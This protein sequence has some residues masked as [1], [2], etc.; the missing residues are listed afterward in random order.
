MSHVY[1]MLYT[2]PDILKSETVCFRDLRWEWP[3]VFGQLTCPCW[4]PLRCRHAAFELSRP[5]LF[6]DTF[7]LKPLFS[8]GFLCCRPHCYHSSR[9]L[10]T[11]FTWSTWHSVPVSQTASNSGI[12]LRNDST[13]CFA[14]RVWQSIKHDGEDVGHPVHRTQSNEIDNS[15]DH[16]IFRFAS[17]WK[18]GDIC[19]EGFWRLYKWEL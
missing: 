11:E 16:C 15:R 3:I 10:V 5:Q 14:A 7:R 9:I 18:L 13:S 1:I 8:T 19:S 17:I 6:S 12:I 2:H 4:R